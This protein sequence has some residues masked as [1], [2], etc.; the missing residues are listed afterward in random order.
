MPEQR[1]EV[2]LINVPTHIR[3]FMKYTIAKCRSWKYFC[4]FSRFNRKVKI[5]QKRVIYTYRYI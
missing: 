4:Y 5:C 3:F 2:T 1:L